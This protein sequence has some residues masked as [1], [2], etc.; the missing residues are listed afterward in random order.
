MQASVGMVSDARCLQAGQVIVEWSCM[1][2]PANSKKDQ[3]AGPASSCFTPA[4]ISPRVTVT[5][6]PMHHDAAMD[7]VIKWPSATLSRSATMAATAVRPRRSPQMIYASFQ[8]QH[9][10]YEAAM[11]MCGASLVSRLPPITPVLNRWR[12]AL[13]FWRYVGFRQGRRVLSRR[14]LAIPM[15][16][17]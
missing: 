8:R 13:A 17:P 4:A 6:A 3:P 10:L 14:P 16:G 12:P 1:T 11:S 9:R 5:H 15:K 2:P 7:L